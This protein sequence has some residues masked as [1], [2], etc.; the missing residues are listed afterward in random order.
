M[1]WIAAK[2]MDRWHRVKA[3]GCDRG[4]F[5]P[6]SYA[7]MVAALV[8]LI[9]AVIIWGQDLADRFMGRLDDFDF[10]DPRPE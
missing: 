6:I 7:L 9:G 3:G 2:L 4:E 8:L 5:G 1:P 10:D